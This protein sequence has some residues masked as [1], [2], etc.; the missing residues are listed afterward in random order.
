LVKRRAPLARQEAQLAIAR[1]CGGS[2]TSASPSSPRG[3]EYQPTVIRAVT[4]L[5]VT[6]GTKRKQAA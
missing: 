6:V 3:A 2:P 5:P 1:C 4:A